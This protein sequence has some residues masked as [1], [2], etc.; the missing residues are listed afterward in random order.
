LRSFTRRSNKCPPHSFTRPEAGLNGD[1][2]LLRGRGRYQNL[3]ART[4][5]PKRGLVSS[6]VQGY[7]E[8][9]ID[10]AQD[11]I[12]SM[13]GQRILLQA[14]TELEIRE[15]GKRQGPPPI[16]DIKALRDGKVVAIATLNAELLGCHGAAC[17]RP[18]AN[19]PKGLGAHSVIEDDLDRISKVGPENALV[20]TGLTTFRVADNTDVGSSSAL[21]CR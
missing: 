16:R 20:L 9:L 14:L 18:V 5:I 8:E 17:S 10:D 3:G 2:Y 15:N 11:A 12:L 6:N 7:F 21:R 4:G 19:R 1:L 13:L